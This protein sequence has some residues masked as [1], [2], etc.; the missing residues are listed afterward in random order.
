MTSQKELKVKIAGRAIGPAHP[1]YIIAEISGN[2][3]GDIGRALALIDAAK[4]SGADAVKLQTYTA[5]TITIDHDGPGFVVESGEWKGW[6]LYDLYEEAHTPWE[7]HP[8]LFERAA[9][10]GLHVF[11][12]PFDDSAVDFLETLD[13]PAYK[14]ASFEIVDHGLIER[15]ARTDKPIIVSTG[16]AAD[17]EIT[18]AVD[19]ARKSVGGLILLHCVSG[20]PT[21]AREANLR[22]IDDMVRRFG[23]PTGLSD[24]TLGTAVTVAAIAAGACVIEK[25]ITLKRADGGPDASFSLEP[26]EFSRMCEESR[27]AWEALGAVNYERTVS[28]AP[29]AGL[30]RS[31]YV[32]S[33][34]GLGQVLTEE[35]VKSIRPGFGLAPRHLK[36]VL[37]HRATRHLPRGT[38][39]AWSDVDAE[40]AD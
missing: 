30:R 39:L 13:P 8:R 1:P 4:D 14:I 37:G 18:E 7:W 6:R 5:D 11:S 38:P 27:A 15:V 33:D 25:H 29:V 31:L 10:L 19:I 24:H 12:S 32:V 26:D 16:M 20:Y 17:G 9:E 22:T 21:P 35:N 3:N 40:K 34:I 36:A 28:E 23:A 2:H